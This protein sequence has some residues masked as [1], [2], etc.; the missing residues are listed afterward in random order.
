MF[1]YKNKE[2]VNKIDGQTEYAPIVFINKPAENYSQDVVGFKSQVETIHQAIKNGANMIGVIADYGTG[3]STIS[4]ILISDVLSNERK[5]STIRVNMWDSISKKSD[6]NDISELTKSFLYQLANGN[7]DNGHMSK[8][9]HYVSK[10]MSKN[11]NTIS[12]ST[13]SAKFWKYGCGAAFLYALY[14]IFSRSDINFI[15]EIGNKNIVKILNLMNDVNPLFFVFALGM[16]IY[17]IMDTSIAFSSWK[18]TGDNHLESNDVF[19]LYDEI[20]TKLIENSSENKQIVFIE[21]LDRI[22]DKALIT[23]FL[24]ELYRF[25]N[26]VSEKLKD[27]FVFIVAIKPEALL[28]TRDVK[29]GKENE[30][31]TFEHLY[32]KVF[33]VTVNLKPIHFEDYESALLAMLDKNKESR[34]RLIGLI[35]EDIA[36][37]HL[38]ESFNWILLGEN[39]TLRDLKDRLNHA[40][41]IMVSLKNKNYKG[42][43]GINF[44]ACTAVAYLESAFPV[45]FYGLVQEEEKFESFIRESYSIKNKLD[46]KKNELIKKYHKI[47]YGSIPDNIGCETQ[48]D[49][50]IDALCKLVL[51]NVFDD[52]FRMYFYTYP[53]NSYIKTVDEK[54]VCNLIKL[55]TIFDNVENLDEMVD[56]IFSSKPKSIVIDTIRNL[57]ESEPYPIVLILNRTLFEYAVKFNPEKSLQ[58]LCQYTLKSKTSDDKIL[59]CLKMIN[60]A[61]I[62]NKEWLISNYSKNILE[63]VSTEELTKEKFM[64]LRKNIIQAFEG[65]I[66][67][68]IDLFVNE[69]VSVS[70]INEDEVK[71]I[72][73]ISNILKLIDIRLVNTK[74]EY[75]FNR[76]NSDKLSSEDCDLASNIYGK[77]ITKDG[78]NTSLGTNILQFLRNNNLINIEFFNVVL[79]TV[80]DT[81]SICAYINEFEVNVLPDEYLRDIDKKVI[82]N[83]LSD[84]LLKRMK[85]NNLF[86]CYILSKAPKNQ[87]DNINYLDDTVRENIISASRVLLAEDETIFILLRKSI[88]RKVQNV[89]NKYGQIFEGEYPIVTKEELNTFNVFLDAIICIDASKLDLEN[90]DFVWEYCNQDNR[91]ANECLS[92]FK[93]LFDKEHKLV[94][95]DRDVARKLIYALD[96]DKIR[97]CELN[98]AQRE[99]AANYVFEL[100]GLSEPEEALKFLR[101]LKTLVPSLEQVIQ[102][103]SLTEDYISLLN[104]LMTYTDTSLQWIESVKVK[105][106]LCPV[107]TDQLY[108]RKY[109][110]NYVIGKSLYENKLVYDKNMLSLEQYFDMYLNRQCM[111]DVMSENEEFISDIAKA[112]LYTQISSIALIKP[113]YYLPQTTDMFEYIWSILSDNEYSE[114]L[115]CIPKIATLDDSKSIQKFL[116]IQENMDKLG[117]Y[118][119]RDRIDFLLWDTQKKHKRDF[120]TCW[121]KN[122]KSKL[123]TLEN[124]LL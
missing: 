3:K 56:R 45:E 116:C 67:G 124:H 10:R 104:D 111:Y 66:V 120:N 9:S 31:K 60:T 113:L 54:D 68:F 98:I 94:V 105:M 91:S 11:F 14:K 48:K 32:S 17:G 87:I 5:Y 107:I 57:N 106:G 64:K 4:D 12:L 25:Q 42:K 52:D 38:P 112:G 88:I 89:Y 20:A 46:D 96:F 92:V 7:D 93:Y 79:N 21:D 85:D 73:N 71:L 63:S 18:K 117:S 114:Y 65:K 43:P 55:P 108:N 102:E 51:D 8:L 82:G 99:E 81:E 122:W 44:T 97:F 118:S 23:E 58:L 37:D 74:M 115:M 78:S 30:D 15:S 36:E 40:I 121:N 33:D 39:L 29:P 6:N 80:D 2:K 13:V 75:I 123:K 69:D 19:E 22:N 47:F 27:K 76:I 109:Y 90:C 95:E 100:L 84:E 77:L 1:G 72:D 26:S 24:K 110:V 62:C 101:H 41:S 16:L 34:E 50:F 59:S 103:S 83:G 61:Q 28:K 35:G 86:V 53:D 49:K 119:M 70:I